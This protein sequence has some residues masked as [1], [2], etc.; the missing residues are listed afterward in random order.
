L[1]KQIARKQNWLNYLLKNLYF[2]NWSYWSLYLFRRNNKRYEDFY[3][4]YCSAYIDFCCYL[5]ISVY[6]TRFGVFLDRQSAT[7]LGK[8]RLRS[9]LPLFCNINIVDLFYL[10]YYLMIFF[11]LPIYLISLFRYCSVVGFFLALRSNLDLRLYRNKDCQ[12]SLYWQ[13]LQLLLLRYSSRFWYNAQLIFRV[14]ILRK[15]FCCWFSS[16]YLFG[17][18]FLVLFF[19]YKYSVQLQFNSVAADLSVCS[20]AYIIVYRQ[21]L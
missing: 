10:F 2:F 18:L 9:L 21:P 8:T 17:I 20:P 4:R 11:S 14:I 13:K 5:I 16:S 19:F 1:Y 15:S 12:R 7:Q 3:W 6:S